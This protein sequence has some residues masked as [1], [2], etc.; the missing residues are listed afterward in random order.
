M[1]GNGTLLKSDGVSFSDYTRNVLDKVQRLGIPIVLVTARPYDKAKATVESAGLKEY[2]VT[3]NGARVVRVADG[4]VLH[5]SWVE[6][7]DAA[8][9]IERIQAAKPGQCFFLQLTKT[10]G[11]VDASHP[12]LADVAPEL[13]DAVIRTFK[14]SPVVDVAVALR[15]ERGT[16]CAKSYVT[17][18]ATTDFEAALETLRIVVGPSWSLRAVNLQYLPG[19]TNTCELQSTSVNK[20]D[21]IAGL[22]KALG[23]QIADVWAFGDDANDARMLDNVG[24]G[25]RMANCKLALEGVGK[26]STEFNNDQDGVAKYLETYLLQNEHSP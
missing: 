14:A 9:A 1:D 7:T 6:S 12:W 3:E 5:E 13:R 25:V 23:I 24:W 21:G 4:V 17:I 10:G 22:C 26:D 20:L 11:L 8:H 2:T 18:P 15:E 19:V 16:L